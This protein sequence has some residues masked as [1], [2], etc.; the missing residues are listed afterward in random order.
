[1]VIERVVW[2]IENS[3]FK[4]YRFD[5]DK[6][7]AQCCDY[8]VDVSNIKQ[9]LPSAEEQTEITKALKS[10]YKLITAAFRQ[11]SAISGIELF[12]IGKNV[13]NDFLKKSGFAQDEFFLKDIGILWNLSNAP[14]S[15]GE[16]FNAGNGLCRYEFAEFLIRLAIDRFYK[17][18]QC[19]S[20]KEAF[21]KFLVEYA[22]PG[23]QKYDL[24]L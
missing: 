23:M 1:M 9:I 10:H 18:K 21:D 8:D 3:S 20:I 6:I 15:K 16:K 12:S 24:S 22:I 17:T 4:D 19:E 7:L 13:L 5:D 2:S 14:Q 11:L